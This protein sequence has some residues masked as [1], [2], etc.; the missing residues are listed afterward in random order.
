M[1]PREPDEKDRKQNILFCRPGNET[2]ERPGRKAKYVRP[3]ALY[4]IGAMWT[5][6]MGSMAMNLMM[7]QVGQT[8]FVIF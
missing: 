8:R 6:A 3:I 4:V 7:H 5:C 2:P 1:F